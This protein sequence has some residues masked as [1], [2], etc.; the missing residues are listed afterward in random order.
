MLLE[1]AVVRGQEVGDG[2]GEEIELFHVDGDL[3]EVLEGFAFHL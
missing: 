3:E 2:I 1:L